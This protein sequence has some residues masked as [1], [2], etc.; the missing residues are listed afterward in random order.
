MKKEKSRLEAFLRTLMRTTPHVVRSLKAL[1]IDDECDQASVNAAAEE[2][3][4]TAINEAI[5]KML[6]AL[7][8]ASYAGYT[9]TPFANVFIDPF[10]HNHDELDDLLPRGLY[11]LPAQTRTATLRAREV[12]GFDP[13]DAQDESSD[14]E[15]HDMVRVI[16]PEEVV[17]LRPSENQRAARHFLPN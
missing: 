10:P 14:S 8:A 13:E 3:D 16:P 4:I 15:G 6:R 5:R 17:L 9:A 2:Y 7:P 1:V 11:H 12:F